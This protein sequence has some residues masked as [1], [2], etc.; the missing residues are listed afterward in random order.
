VIEEERLKVLLQM[1]GATAHELSQPLM[2]LLGSIEMVEMEGA[3][4]ERVAHHI[5]NI[6][7]AGTRISE[8]IRKIHTVRR[9][10]TKLHDQGAH[11]INLDQKVNILSI[12]DT[13]EDFKTIE[14]LLNDEKA[15]ELCWASTLKEA[16]D[17]LKITDISLIFLDHYLPDG[18]G[19]DFLMEAQQ[20]A[21]DIPVV[22]ITG[23]GDEMLASQTIQAGDK[24]LK[25]ISQLISSGFRQNDLK[26][27]Y[28][29]EEFA[30]IFPHTA[31]Q[32]AVKACETFRESLAAKHFEYD[33]ARFQITV[34]MGV[35]SFS[36]EGLASHEALIKQADQALYQAKA[37]GRDRLLVHGAS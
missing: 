13:A 31:L 5:S 19:F 18:T 9:P 12:E 25:E 6:K 20:K 14:A 33:S 32:D 23:H 22:I 26:C 15:I 21:I 37:A 10:E 17:I 24:V 8:T 29:G 4:P 7:R 34:S 2:L 1:A 16:F 35:T 30:V 3:I 36:L 11:I 28:G 27:R